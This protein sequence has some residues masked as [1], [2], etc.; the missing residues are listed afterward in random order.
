[1]PKRRKKSM[2]KK[3]KSVGIMANKM[4]LAAIVGII[5]IG[6]GVAAFYMMPSRDT[7]TWDAA[8]EIIRDRGGVSG[9][10]SVPDDTNETDTTTTTT[11]TTD[12]TTVTDETVEVPIEVD[13][14][15]YTNPIQMRLYG[16]DEVGGRHEISESGPTVQSAY[17]GEV[18]IFDIE[19]DIYFNFLLDVEEYPERYVGNIGVMIMLSLVDRT[20]QDASGNL[21][22][23]TSRSEVVYPGDFTYNLTILEEDIATRGNGFVTVSLVGDLYRLFGYGDITDVNNALLDAARSVTLMN[24]VVADNVTVDI[25]GML[26]FSYGVLGYYIV[27]EYGS[28]ANRALKRMTI[29]SQPVV[30]EYDIPP[31]LQ[32]S[33]YDIG[34]YEVGDSMLLVIGLGVFGMIMV[35]YYLSRRRCF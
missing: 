34:G 32:M 4:V 17:L 26:T 31:T 11:D 16:I 21:Y 10:P 28:A 7:A 2:R 22:G 24:Q 14:Y 29:T 8:T 18:Q 25:P 5:I 13:E 19:F 27:N 3:K 12:T 30:S 23:D 20:V 1:M 9:V 6:G 35:Y 33:V 15:L